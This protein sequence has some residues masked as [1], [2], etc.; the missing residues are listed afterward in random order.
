MNVPIPVCI[1]PNHGQPMNPD[2]VRDLEPYLLYIEAEH[3]AEFA[4]W[5]LASG[6]S[7]LAMFLERA[8]AERYRDEAGLDDAWY[9][10]QPTPAVLQSIFEACRAHGIEYAVLNP[11]LHQARRIWRLEEVLQQSP[12][13]DG[14][15]S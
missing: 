2:P 15:D 5:G 13:P 10:Y 3:Q 9:V 7:A 8:D 6:G 1:R 12:S 11:D 14:D 4:V